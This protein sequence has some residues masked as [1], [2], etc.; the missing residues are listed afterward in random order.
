MLSTCVLGNSLPQ[1]CRDEC[2]LARIEQNINLVSG[3]HPEPIQNS[4]SMCCVSESCRECS[5][6]LGALCA[7]GWRSMA[8]V[9]RVEVTSCV[10]GD[11][12]LLFPA[13]INI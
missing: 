4:M 9:G 6:G 3:R 13:V 10:G 8:V 12:D 1:S 7:L 11:R 2:S 5:G